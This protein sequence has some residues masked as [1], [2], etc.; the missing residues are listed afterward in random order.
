MSIFISDKTIKASLLTTSEL[1]QEIALHLFQ[2]GCLTLEY[3]S[4]LAEMQLNDFRQFLKR[5]NVPL[6][7][8]KEL[9]GI[10]AAMIGLF[11]QT[12]PPA[13]P[14]NRPKIARRNARSIGCPSIISV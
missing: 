9:T 13:S 10:G 7:R 4:Q 6:Y 1:R 14:N 5:R 12:Q 11:C 8:F 3:A 2:I